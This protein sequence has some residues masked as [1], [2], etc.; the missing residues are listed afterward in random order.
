MIDISQYRA[1]IGLYNCSVSQ[2]YV[3]INGSVRSSFKV[4][5][6]GGYEGGD[7]YIKTD[8]YF[9]KSASDTM[10]L[11]YSLFITYFLIFCLASATHLQ[12]C[13]S[14][15]IFYLSNSSDILN[16]STDAAH[17]QFTINLFL[18]L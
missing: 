1:T 6:F 4:G 13:T 3:H 16:S 8:Q 2:G 11:L 10:I 17:L 5:R 9:K 12:L 7:K 15:F 18:P 14:Q